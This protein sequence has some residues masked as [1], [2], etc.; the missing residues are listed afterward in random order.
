MEKVVLNGL[1][2]CCEVSK[3]D[4]SWGTVS[5]FNGIMSSFN[6]W[7]A[8]SSSC[9]E[10]GLDS[11]C[12]DFRGQLLSQKPKNDITFE[13]HSNDAKLLLEHYG[14]KSTHIVGTSYGGI[15]AIKFALDYPELVDSLTLIDT[16]SE[17][18]HYF[19]AWVSN[20]KLWAQQILDSSGDFQTQSKVLFMKNMIP[21]IYSNDMIGSDK[22][23]LEERIESFCMVGSDYFESL[24]KLFSNT[25]ENTRFTS[26]LKEIKC[27]VLVVCGQED[28]LTPPKFSKLI[29]EHI[30]SSDYVL[31]PDAGHALVYE[32]TNVL[33]GLLNGF[34]LGLKKQQ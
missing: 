14:I 20:F 22:A 8:Y 3:A 5:F 10:S 31:I 9:N 16:L 15:A 7:E 18:D 27:P 11:F 1:E 24:I 23:A 17:T 29:R 6:S 34:L 26:R 25:I 28:R 19:K 30:K 21:M 4:N 33:N 13:Q 2:F 32:K 12:H